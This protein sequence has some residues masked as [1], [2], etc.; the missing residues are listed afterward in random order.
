MEFQKYT[1][2]KRLKFISSMLKQSITN[3][4]EVLDIGCGNGIISRSLGA[5]GF[6]VLG[7][8]VSEKAIG[9]AR[10]LNN[11]SNVRFEVRSAEQLVADGQQ[12]EAI[13]CSE[14][15]E[16]LHQPGD[17]LKVLRLILKDNGVLIVTVPNGNGGR[18]L[19]VTRPVQTI[20]KHFP[21]CWKWLNRV[22]NILGY[23]GTT[24][25]SDADD[26]SHVQFF[27]IESLSAL[28]S[29]GGF[30]ISHWGKSNF[31]ED[32]FPFSLLTR[33]IRILQQLDCKLAEFLPLRM[34]GGFFTVWK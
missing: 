12:Y 27:T 20:M 2:Q 9:K 5:L 22:K 31:I 29:K 3:G 24:V 15:L 33:R 28:A 34:T 26:L 8:D 25:Q 21:L 17:V 10:S 30:I 1:D 11:L 14:V 32:V 18:E 13:I 23:K 19:L 4:A 6:N 16:H 7:V